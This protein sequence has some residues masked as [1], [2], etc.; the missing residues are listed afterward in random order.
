MQFT[1]ASALLVGSCRSKQIP[2]NCS[3]DRNERLQDQLE[4]LT[5]VF[6]KRLS[7]GTDAFA[8]CEED[9]VEEGVQN[10]VCDAILPERRQVW[11]DPANRSPR[12]GL[13]TP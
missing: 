4:E 2:D 13:T 3:E 8:V 6:M 11:L 12:R 7:I 5:G 10:F 9:C 1:G